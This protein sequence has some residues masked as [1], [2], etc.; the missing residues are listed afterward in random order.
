MTR[1][2]SWAGS[3]LQPFFIYLIIMVMMM[4]MLM[5]MTMTMT[6]KTRSCLIIAGGK[7][8]INDDCEQNDDESKILMMGRTS[9]GSI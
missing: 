3:T 6:M 1:T 4:L 7:V 5:M 2:R 8:N 9:R